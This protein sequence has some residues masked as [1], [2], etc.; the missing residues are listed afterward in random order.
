MANRLPLLSVVVPVFHNAE[1]LDELFERIRATLE[2]HASELSYEVIFVEDR[3]TDDTWKVLQALREKFPRQVTLVRLVRNF[4]QVAAL[5]AGYR[6]A[7]GDCCV[8]MAA[9]LQAPPELIRDMFV[10]WRA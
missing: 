7:A 4:G 6:T 8:S 10:A 2:P 5:L 3:S 9:D 1:T